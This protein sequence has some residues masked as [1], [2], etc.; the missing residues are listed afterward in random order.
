M[1]FS[2]FKALRRI[3]LF[4]TLTL[5]AVH[6]HQAVAQAADARFK[7]AITAEQDLFP[8]TLGSLRNTGCDNGVCEGAA[9]NDQSLVAYTFETGTTGT[10]VGLRVRYSPAS[11]APQITSPIAYLTGPAVTGRLSDPDVVVD[12]VAPQDV[13]TNPNT[14]FWQIMIVYLA[15]IPVGSN[16]AFVN[17][18]FAE[19][20]AYDRQ[21][22]TLAQTGVATRLDVVNTISNQ[23][24]CT[25]PNADASKSA[26]YPGSP[27]PPILES[28]AAITWQQGTSIFLRTRNMREQNFASGGILSPI[29]TVAGSVSAN[30]TPDVAVNRVMGGVTGSTQI[31]DRAYVC[32]AQNTGTDGTA[33]VVSR[34]F[35]DLTGAT[36]TNPSYTLFGGTVSATRIAAIAGAVDEWAMVYV[37]QPT[38]QT[39]GDGVL[40][41]RH[42]G[43]DIHDY[44]GNPNCTVQR[45]V[46]TYATHI[47]QTSTK[48]PHIV[49]AW[50]DASGCIS[51]GSNGSNV[52]SKRYYT[53]GS[54][55]PENSFIYFGVNSNSANSQGTPAICDRY[56]YSINQGTNYMW[57]EFP[58]GSTTS[59]KVEFVSSLAWN[60]AVRPASTTR[61]PLTQEFPTE[62][63]K[64]FFVGADSLTVPSNINRLEIYPNPAVSTSAVKIKLPLG[65]IAQSLELVDVA[66]GRIVSRIAEGKIAEAKGDVALSDLLLDH[67]RLGPYLLKLTTSA[68]TFST[69]FNHQMMK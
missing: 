16:G 35:L 36:I 10:G 31:I 8:N 21:N 67:M 54:V 34:P 17:H 61:L 37:E 29:R 68:G 56:Q 5:G 69:R 7:A 33:I 45:P 25:S 53:S 50:S 18:P 4:G 19:V 39:T 26:I 23:T 42:Q 58:S 64:T 38:G 12:Q 44:L 49:T 14:R 2:F 1:Q 52:V 47:E 6:N 59:G 60:S 46:V 13:V 51:G 55:L 11:N 57:L 62:A 20:W 41:V 15:P 30:A 22:N 66:T 65:E 40:M 28:F 24:A 9:F 3:S 43:F 63:N 32:Y 27:A 48:M